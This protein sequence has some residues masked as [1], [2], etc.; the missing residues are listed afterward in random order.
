[1]EW[2]THARIN[3]GKNEVI[4]MDISNFKKFLNTTF[5]M[6]FHI[7]KD[8]IDNNNNDK[9]GNQ[10]NK[11][12]NKEEEKKEDNINN[13]NNNNNNNSNKSVNKNSKFNGKNQHNFS[14]TSNKNVKKISKQSTIMESMGARLREMVS[15]ANTN[16]IH[17]PIKRPSIKLP[18]A[19]SQKLP[20][21]FSD[22]YGFSKF[23]FCNPIIKNFNIK[24]IG[25]F[26]NIYRSGINPN[27]QNFARDFR[28]A[29]IRSQIGK[30]SIFIE[31][32]I[33]IPFKCVT[34]DYVQLNVGD[35]IAKH[36]IPSGLSNICGLL[37]Q[38]NFD[39][40]DWILQS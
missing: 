4:Q 31:G 28:N 39:S 27:K 9:N 23:K 11:N 12:E 22:N 20:S 2:I 13:N 37:N 40:N 8:K 38:Q 21:S 7:K 34:V 29:V 19:S 35:P 30:S 5:N 16:D 26:A 33:F 17:R 14:N 24:F 25:N 32:N 1:M 3:Q 10:E 36:Q 6:H 18:N 15:E